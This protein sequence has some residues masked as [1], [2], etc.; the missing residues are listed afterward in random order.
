MSRDDIKELLIKKDDKDFE[1][2]QLCKQIFTN[3]FFRYDSSIDDYELKDHVPM[4][5]NCL[6]IK[7][8]SVESE[9]QSVVFL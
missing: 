7:W 9:Y 2:C 3:L 4:C 6:K 1:V 5:I 8:E